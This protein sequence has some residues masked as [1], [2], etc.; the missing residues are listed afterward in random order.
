MTHLTVLD[1][2]GF[3]GL[4]SFIGLTRWSHPLQITLLE[5]RVWYISFL[6][7]HLKLLTWIYSLVSLTWRLT[8]FW[9][10]LLESRTC[11]VFKCFQKDSSSYMLLYSRIICWNLY[12]YDSLRFIILSVCSCVRLSKCFPW[13]NETHMRRHL[14]LS[15]PTSN[16]CHVLSQVSLKTMGL[17]RLRVSCQY[18]I[19]YLTFGFCYQT[20]YLNGFKI[21][22]KTR[23]ILHI[24]YD[25]SVKYKSN[26]IYCWPY[27]WNTLRSLQF[28][29][30][31]GWYVNGDLNLLLDYPPNTRHFKHFALAQENP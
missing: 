2:V 21:L 1:A 7:I 8:H 13:M 6:I 17:D 5:S 24:K 27:T 18:H 15:A 29:N 22:Y 11:I 9:V 23:K 16:R 19:K 14:L 20:K 31:F 28:V 3:S 4:A 12:T 10:Y 26:V 30:V 25:F